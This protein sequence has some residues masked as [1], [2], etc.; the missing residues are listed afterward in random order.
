VFLASLAAAVLLFVLLCDL[1]LAPV[2]AAASVGIGLSIPMFLTFGTMLD[3]VMLGLPFA[4][5]YLVLWQR[6]LSGRPKYLG[7]ATAAAA[8]CLVAWEGVVLVAVTMVVM[9]A[10]RR[11]RERLTAII[12]AGGGAASAVVVTGLWQVW[13]YGGLNDV[14]DQ[15]A[16][17][18]GSSGFS[19]GDYVDSQFNALR[20]TF[21][22]P[23]IVVLAVGV[24]VMVASRRFRP[25]GIAALATP[26]VYAGGFRQGSYVHDYWNYWLVITFVVA[27]GAI[28]SLL[29]HVRLRSWLPTACVVAALLVVVG[30]RTELDEQRLRTDGERYAQTEAGF[31]EPARGQQ[32]VPLVSSSLGPPGSLATWVFPQARFYFGVP[33]RFATARAAASYTRRHPDA[34]VVLNTG[35]TGG[36]ELVRGRDAVARLG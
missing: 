5:G 8:V 9:A 1:D 7:L 2:L 10:V 4:A 30:F 23:A 21:G 12:A 34:W 24:V 27:I 35:A 3:T 17:R 15:G 20:E 31:T 18:A 29:Q 25:V 32:W 16:L 11:D 13:V 19:F 22:V 36:G 26:I 28:A 33:L 14:L 6:G